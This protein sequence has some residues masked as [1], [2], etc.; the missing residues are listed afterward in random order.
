MKVLIASIP[1]PAHLNPLLPSPSYLVEPAIDRNRLYAGGCRWLE[2][3]I[4]IHRRQCYAFHRLATSNPRALD[5]GE[6]TSLIAAHSAGFNDKSS[7]DGLRSRAPASSPG[8]DIGDAE[9]RGLVGDFRAD[10]VACEDCN[11]E[12][13]TIPSF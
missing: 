13:H 10:A 8:G 11:F 9:L 1:S 5:T 7:C 6:S 12:T 3:D 4:T 2:T